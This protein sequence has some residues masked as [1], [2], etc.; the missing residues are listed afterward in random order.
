DAGEILAVQRLENLNDAPVLKADQVAAP[1]RRRLGRERPHLL[2]Q[3][4]DRPGPTARRGCRRLRGRW[5]LRALCGAGRTSLGFRFAAV[6]RTVFRR[7]LRLRICV[8]VVPR[9]ADT[10]PDMRAARAR[11]E[12]G[13]TL[14]DRTADL[15]EHGAVGVRDGELVAAG[16]H[17]VPQLDAALLSLLAKDRGDLP[18]PVVPRLAAEPVIDVLEEREVDREP[19]PCLV[20]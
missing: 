9:G 16:A 4:L 3:L 8:S 18:Q 20:R 11:I 17:D 7:L 1:N 6:A 5:R 14:H 12:L 13:H 2:A 10:E 19:V 15:L